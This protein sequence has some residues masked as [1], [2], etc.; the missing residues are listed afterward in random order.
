M[1][2][3]GAEENQIHLA[4][5]VLLQSSAHRRSSFNNILEIDMLQLWLM[6]LNSPGSNAAESP[7]C[8][9]LATAAAEA[10]KGL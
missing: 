4:G 7:G 3:D 1:T 2:G 8:Q 6:I 9:C 5:L 10:I